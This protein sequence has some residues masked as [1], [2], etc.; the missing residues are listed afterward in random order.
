LVFRRPKDSDLDCGSLLLLLEAETAFESVVLREIV[1]DQD[2]NVCIM[3]GGR[4]A[5][6]DFLD[7]RFCVVGDDENQQ[8][9]PGQIS[10]TGYRKF[11][12]AAAHS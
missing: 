6:E 5:A 2:F 4:D 11:R 10:L 9:F 3:K 1:D 12:D 8:P 7:R